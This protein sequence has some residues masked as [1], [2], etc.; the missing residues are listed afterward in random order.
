MV[1]LDDFVRLSWVKVMWSCMDFCCLFQVRRGQRTV[2]SETKYIELMVV[3]D[4]EL[5]R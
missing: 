2:Q 1:A 3:N 5:V 4:H